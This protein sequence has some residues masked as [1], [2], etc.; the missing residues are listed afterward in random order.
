MIR[1]KAWD[2]D[3][4]HCLKMEGHAG[5]DEPGKDV[6]CAA[7]SILMYTLRARQQEL[8]DKPFTCNMSESGYVLMKVSDRM[9]EPYKTVLSGLKLL[10]KEYPANVVFTRD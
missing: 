6:V 9:I 8:H 5:Y 10:S 7:V 2:E 4:M 1:I 3:N